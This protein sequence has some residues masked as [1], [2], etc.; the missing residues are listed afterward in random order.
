MGLNRRVKGVFEVR[1]RKGEDEIEGSL[2]T[3]A[4]AVRVGEYVGDL[5][6]FVGIYLVDVLGLLFVGK[7]DEELKVVDV[8]FFLYEV[9]TDEGL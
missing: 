1:F 6:L 4:D 7:E 5:F 9:N 3:V 8:G 2:E